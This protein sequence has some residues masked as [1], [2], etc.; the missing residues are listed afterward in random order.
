MPWTRASELS[1]AVACPASTHLPRV[2]D[3]PGDGAAWGTLVHAWKETGRWPVDDLRTRRRAAALVA[4]GLTRGD[5]WPG[6]E[7]E[8]TYAVSTAARGAM[9]ARETLDTPEQRNAFAAARGPEWVTGTADWVGDWFGEPWIDDLKT[10]VSHPIDFAAHRAGDLA[11]DG[12]DPWDLWQLRFYALGEIV[13]RNREA[14]SGVWV[15]VTWWPRY[16]ADSAPVRIGPRRVAAAEVLG[17]IGPLLE[18][19]RRNAAESAAGPAVARAGDHCTFCRSRAYCPVYT[20]D[21]NT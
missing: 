17:T 8:V 9:V 12:G 3:S 20:G 21:N 19:A 18:M 16:P 15:S 1:R 2:P 10:G 13:W 5:L 7:H 4:A 6:G 11:D 14:P